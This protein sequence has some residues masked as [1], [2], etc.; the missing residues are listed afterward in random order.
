MSHILYYSNYCN[1]CK[2]L[3]QN[4]AKNY[5]SKEIHFICVDK[6]IQEQEGTYLILEKGEKVILPPSITNVP[7]LLLLNHGH[8]V[9]FGNEIS[10]HLVAKN[11][12]NTNTNTN[13]NNVINSSNNV[14]P[15]AF[16]FNGGVYGVCSDNFSFWDL[17]DDDLSTKGNGGMRQLY[18]YATVDMNNG[19]ETPPDNYAPDKVGDVSLE[20]LQQER[21]EDL[22]NFR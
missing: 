15:E 13:T 11:N 6:R 18:N 19:I 1:N 5:N 21:N 10:N 9:V 20:K 12:H 3:L 16:D 8:R 7:A 22:P 17:N 14:D 2:N 4:L